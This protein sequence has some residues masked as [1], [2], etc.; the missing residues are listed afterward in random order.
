MADKELELGLHAKLPVTLKIKQN[1]D[2]IAYL[3][4]HAPDE[5]IIKTSKPQVIKDW[6]ELLGGDR[7]THSYR[8]FFLTTYK[9]CSCRVYYNKSIR[10]WS[11]LPAS[12]ITTEGIRIEDIVSIYSGKKKGKN[13][14]IINY[15]RSG[16]HQYKFPIENPEEWI[17]EINAAIPK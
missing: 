14:I 3:K 15:R 6:W 7:G 1:T 11:A 16:T 13:C 4:Q 17:K 12:G 10:G 8:F 9:L 5:K 2:V